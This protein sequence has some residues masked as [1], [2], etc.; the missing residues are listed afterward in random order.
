MAIFCY[1]TTVGVPSKTRFHLNNT[2]K[3]SSYASATRRSILKL[4][5]ANPITF[6]R[7]RNIKNEIF[8]SQLSTYLK[9]TWHLG[10]QMNH[11]SVQTKLDSLFKPAL[12]RSKTNTSSESSIAGSMYCLFTVFK[13]RRVIFFCLFL[14]TLL[15]SLNFPYICVLFFVLV[16]LF[17]SLFQIIA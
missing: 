15:M 14:S 17:A 1:L 7:D 3:F 2:Y 13:G 16:L 4:P 8:C 5:L 11:L 10:R 6:N 9:D 12:L